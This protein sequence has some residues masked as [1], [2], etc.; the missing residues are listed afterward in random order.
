MNN[1]V[2][3]VAN[4]YPT[5]QARAE[6]IEILHRTQQAVH[7]SEGGCELYALHESPEQLVMIEKWT[8]QSSLEEHFRGKPFAELG[9]QLAGKLSKDVEIFQLKP[10]PIGST[11]QGVL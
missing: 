7:R 3:V 8:D 1:T 5:E 9:P 11:G 10:L 2:V 6:V 4:I